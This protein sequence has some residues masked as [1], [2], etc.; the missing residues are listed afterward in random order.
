M[1]SLLPEDSLVRLRA[2]LGEKLGGLNARGVQT[3]VMADVEGI[4][5]NQRLQQFSSDHTTDITKMLQDLVSKEFLVKKGYGRW[6]SYRLAERVAK[7]GG[8]SEGTPDTTM[9]DPS[10]SAGNSSHNAEDSSHNAGNS[11][12]NAGN[13]SHNAG[14][15]SHNAEDSSHNAGNSSHNA[16]NSSQSNQFDLA[17][18]IIAE[19]ARAKSR[20][21]PESMR[22]VLTA[23]CAV[24]ELSLEEIGRMLHRNARG[25]RNRYLRPMVQSGRMQLRFPDEPNH[26]KQA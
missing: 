10:H 3:L 20:L 2:V 24:S 12:H 17:L 18:L 13:S 22:E 16:G 19:Q 4:V 6:A 8:N 23:L 26:P 21:T 7:S 15:S 1:V 14:N 9:G 11:S 25:I 5:T